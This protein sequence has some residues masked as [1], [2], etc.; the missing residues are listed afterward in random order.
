MRFLPHSFCRNA[1]KWMELSSWHLIRAYTVVLT[2]AGN[3]NLSQSV[4]VVSA[5][6]S[7]INDTILPFVIKEYLAG[8]NIWGITV[9]LILQ[10]FAYHFYDLWCSRL[11][12]VLFWWWP[13]SHFLIPS[14]PIDLLV[15]FLLEKLK[16]FSPLPLFTCSL[17]YV[18]IKNV[19]TVRC[20]I[21]RDSHESGLCIVAVLIYLMPDGPTGG[22]GSPFSVAPSFW[23]VPSSIER[24]LTCLHIKM[25]QQLWDQPVPRE[26]HSF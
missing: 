8:D 18:S 25:L 21:L 16:H 3:V 13:C 10:F 22:Q 15:G 23:H 6:C 24:T 2:H 26:N 9:V 5:L 4:T 11:N 7:L 19:N 12:S 14:T 1:P 20:K 17:V